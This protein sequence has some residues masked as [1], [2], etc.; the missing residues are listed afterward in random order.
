VDRDAR[1]VL[2]LGGVSGAGKTTAASEIGRRLSL[3]WLMVDD[4][5][6]ALQRSQVTLPRAT[7]ALYYFADFEQ[8]RQV[9][10][11][12]PERRRDA[13][14]ATG[15]VMAPAIEAVVENHLDQ[16]HPAIVEGDGILPS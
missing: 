14:I 16:R 5:R 9:W 13:F 15:D 4:F 7:E 3:P 12:R 2:L 8:R 11:E 10:Q 1:F 6:L